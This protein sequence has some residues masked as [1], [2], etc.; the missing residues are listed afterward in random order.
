MNKFFNWANRNILN[1]FLVFLLVL[2]IAPILA[3]ILLHFGADM[4]AKAIYTVY[5]FFCHQQHWKSLHLFDHQCAWCTRDMFIWGS[6]LLVLILVKRKNIQP[7][8]FYSLVLYSIPMAMD[9]GLQ[10][11]GTLIGYSSSSSFYTSNN[12]FRMLTG[13]LFGGAMGLFMFTRIKE[14]S[15]EEAKSSKIT[16]NAK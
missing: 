12:F 4:P 5:S 9:G 14:I 3:P 16:K 13:T 8:T 7:L 6:M 15:N 1:L 11:V 10:T 2:N